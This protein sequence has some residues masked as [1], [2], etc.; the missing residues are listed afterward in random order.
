MAINIEWYTLPAQHNNADKEKKLLYPRMVKNETVDFRSFCKKVAKYG[1]HTKGTV[2]TVISDMIDVFGELLH[3]G[4]T[5]NLEDLGVFRLSIG[6]NVDI[7]TD[8]PF[9]KRN[10][11]VRG[12]NFQPSKTLMSTIGTPSFRNISKDSSILATPI[13]H[14]QRV[15]L[16][17]FKTHNSITRSQ[18]EE[19]CRL[20]R[21][22]AYVRLK[23]LVGSGFLIKAGSNKETKY[24][25]G[26]AKNNTTFTV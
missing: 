10:I 5:V 15:L 18:F 6:T 23:A 24:I 21:T 19:L 16:E 9:H 26:T 17:Y 4:K 25:L 8:V 22:T 1:A 11:T 7:T 3:D 14:F 20:K 12:V 13:E 2:E